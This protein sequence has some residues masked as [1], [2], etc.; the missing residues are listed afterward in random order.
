M[1]KT[2]EQG[3]LLASLGVGQGCLD[4]WR[5]IRLFRPVSQVS[6]GPRGTYLL[7]RPFASISSAARKGAISGKAFFRL[8]TGM[9]ARAVRWW[10]ETSANAYTSLRSLCPL[11]RN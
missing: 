1:R 11:L 3:P 8:G 2:Y 4:T 5:E 7:R 6:N 9:S 10:S